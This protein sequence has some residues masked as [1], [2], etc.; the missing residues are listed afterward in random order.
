MH[1]VDDV[2]L[3]PAELGRIVHLFQQLADFLHAAVAGR[4]HFVHVKGRAAF[5]HLAGRAFPAGVAVPGVLAVDGPR[6]DAGGAGFAG[7]AAAAEQVG[8]GNAARVHLV[9]QRAHDG[10]LAH[11]IR[12]SL[13]P[14]DPVQGLVQRCVLHSIS[15]YLYSH[16]EKSPKSFMA[17]SE[18]GL[19]ETALISA[20]PSAA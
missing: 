3:V 13:G 5:N 19:G 6:Q 16:R 20:L 14:P 17:F 1:F 9:P 12:K 10:L 18:G 7:A 15:G 11:H 8:V 4:V 2:H